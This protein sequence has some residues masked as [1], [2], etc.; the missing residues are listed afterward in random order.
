MSAVI[1]FVPGTHLLC[2]A[3]ITLRKVEDGFILDRIEVDPENRGQGIMGRAI[4][5]L[6]TQAIAQGINIG[7][8]IMADSHD[9]YLE[10]KMVGLFMAAGFKPLKMD[11]EVYRKELDLQ[12]TPSMQAALKKSQKQ[13]SVKIDCS[14][15]PA[16]SPREPGF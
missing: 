16:Y 1:K 5:A 10:E 2:G 3:H 9:D 4:N 11:G 7:L 12:P 15:I 6:A 14:D 13:E 8:H